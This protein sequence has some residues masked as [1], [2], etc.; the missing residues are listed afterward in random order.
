MGLSGHNQRDQRVALLGVYS[1]L[2]CALILMPIVYT[3]NLSII[4]GKS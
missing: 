3:T 4:A 1:V 2:V